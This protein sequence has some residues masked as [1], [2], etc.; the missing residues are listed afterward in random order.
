MVLGSLLG[1]ASVNIVINAVDK[2]SSVFGKAQTQL[3][4]LLGFVTKNRAAFLGLAT[5]AVAAGAGITAVFFKATQ[6]AIA[7]EEVNNRFQTVFSNVSKSANAMAS[8]LQKDFRISERSA[9]DFLGSTGDILVGLGQTEEQALKLANAATVLA[10][11]LA[12]F[13]NVPVAQAA[14]AI[15][16][17]LVGERESLK[18]LG[19]VIREVDVKQVLLARGQEELTGTALNAAKAQATYDLII[20]QSTKAQG[21]AIR[22]QDDAANQTKALK[23]QF[24][25]LSD[26][27]G[28]VLLPAYTFLIGK[29]MTVVTWFKSLSGE[30]KKFLVIGGVVAAAFFFIA[31]GLAAVALILP[32]VIGG[33]GF[34][35][36]NFAALSLAALPFLIVA[37][38]IAA[39]IAAI[40]FAIVNWKAIQERFNAFLKLSSLGFQ[41][42]KVDALLVWEQIKLGLAN[43]VNFSVG[44][45]EGFLK[46]MRT[47]LNIIISIVN[48]IP[49]VSVPL[50]P[51]IDFSGAIIQTEG[52]KKVVKD[53]ALESLVLN[54]QMNELEMTSSAAFNESVKLFKG[55]ASVAE[56]LKDSLKEVEAAGVV[57]LTAGAVSVSEKTK[58][59]AEEKEKRL[60]EGFKQDVAFIR[61]QQ[62]AKAEVEASEKQKRQVEVAGQRNALRGE[63]SSINVNIGT[64]QGL[65][66]EAV[67]VALAK[68]LKNVIRG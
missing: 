65:S 33:V 16:S 25:D 68:E 52:M 56:I 23:E 54:A 6:G 48:R 45:F 39:A 19:I 63:T 10:L 9:K 46:K 47:T 64:V 61:R 28:A 43:M 5:A 34:L 66:A 26:Q 57:G 8:T 7:L 41:K 44:L 62:L 32:A 2:F 1:G 58:E 21:D 12:S 67:S 13:T 42:F 27:I 20:Q 3:S 24:Q 37:I 11:D 51:E 35:T 29:V 22:T 40:I 15:N 14:K 4:G 50:I 53:L 55:Q 17:A 30:N 18:T 36:A 59:T 38:A 49:G 60:Q 31:A